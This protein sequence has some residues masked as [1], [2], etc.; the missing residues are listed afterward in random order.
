MISTPVSVVNS[1]KSKALSAVFDDFLVMTDYESG[2]ITVL[3]AEEAHLVDDRPLYK[4]LTGNLDE[5]RLKCDKPAFRLHYGP[6]SSGIWEAGA[7]EVLSYGERILNVIPL[8]RYK[9]RG[10][11]ERI[12]GKKPEQAMLEVERICGTFSAS[13]STAF[14]MAVERIAGIEVDSG[15]KAS[16]ILAVELERI[17]NHVHSIYRVAVAASQKVAVSHLSALEEDILRLN[18]RLFGHRYSFGFNGIGEVRL[19][20]LRELERLNKIEKEFSELVEELS[21]SKIFIDRLHNTAILSAEDI[22]ELDAIGIAAKGS[23]VDRDIRKFSDNYPGFKPVVRAEG[24]SLSRILVRIEEV[25]QSMDIIREIEAEIGGE[26]SKRC[27]DVKEKLENASGEAMAFVE[28]PAGDLLVY[29]KIGEGIVKKFR[30]RGASS[31][32]FL[33]FAKGVEGN[34]FTDYP[35]ALESFG[36]SFADAEV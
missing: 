29:V 22:L 21:V 18:F 30:V 35:F 24:D 17:Y 13:Y 12:E 16:R 36:L 1:V 33:A 2:E 23:G 26:G 9:R 34:I 15:I 7:F 11:T 4:F 8:C 31:V 25:K 5:L 14:S 6:L 3:P 32:N 19:R 20:N 28:S 27:A 10:I